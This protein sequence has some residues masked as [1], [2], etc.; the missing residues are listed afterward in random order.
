EASR[1]PVPGFGV[2]GLRQEVLP[3]G[4]PPLVGRDDDLAFVRAQWRRV[5]RD[6]RAAVVLVTGDAGMGKTRLLE[7]L[8]EE[9]GAPAAVAH[10]RYPAYGGLGGPQVAKDIAEQLGPMGELDVD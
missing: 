7:E 10:A 5:V 6:E 4:G 2:V 3:V 9:V 1:L 8:E